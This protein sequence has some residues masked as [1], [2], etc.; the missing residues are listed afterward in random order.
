MQDKLYYA[1]VLNLCGWEQS[2][3]VQEKSRVEEAFQILNIGPEDMPHTEVWIRESFNTEL[4]GVRKALGVWIK[5]LIDLVLARKEG[6]K[7]IYYSFP[8][9]GGLG[10]TASMIGGENVFCACPGVIAIIALGGIL[11][12]IDP[13]LEAG[14]EALPP[15]RALCALNKMTIGGVI[16]GVFP[17]PDLILASSCF[18][19]QGP[20]ADE[21]LHEI[22]GIP[23]IVTDNIMDSLWG[24]FPKLKPERISYLSKEIKN[25]WDKI[26]EVLGKTAT[27]EDWAFHEEQY[28]RFFTA[29]AKINE[30]MRSDP[31]PLSQGELQLVRWGK[32]GV[33]YAQFPRLL[34]AMDVLIPEL[35]KR[36]KEGK[37]P[38]P[39]GA[40]RVLSCYLPLRYQGLTRLIETVGIAIPISWMSYTPAMAQYVPSTYTTVEERLAEAEL[41]R[42]MY[43]DTSG[44]LHFIKQACKE[45]N[46]DG[47]LWDWPNHCR[48]FV[49]TGFTYKKAI[50]EE[51]GIPVLS[52]ET[53][54]YDNRTYSTE[55][56]RTRIETFAQLLI[57]R[58]A[59][60]GKKK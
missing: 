28:N 27:P 6:K 21:W 3:I 32:S 57:A 12:K 47:V 2:E 31:V 10:F 49:L 13:F 26:M 50:E 56:L 30:Y 33:S 15:G 11:N 25:T 22:Y 18:C 24:E 20:K 44:I 41:R 5:D 19:D 35:E 45:W 9:I 23:W 17:A 54:L 59:S 39:K 14:E 38:V 55:T 4:M 48:P 8:T 43:Y 60:T 51:L 46:V 29:T 1:D 34:Q 16:K 37:G 36:V 58:K 7:I 40:P 52:L 53:D 42:G